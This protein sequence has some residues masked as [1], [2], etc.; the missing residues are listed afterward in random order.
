MKTTQKETILNHLREYKTIT[1]LDAI[2]KY[3]ITR[4]SGVIFNLKEEGYNI[5]SKLKK[6]KTRFGYTQVSEYTLCD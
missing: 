4:L 3:G 2:K 5:T 1:P 6:V